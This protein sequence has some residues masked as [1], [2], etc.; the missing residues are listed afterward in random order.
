MRI[1]SGRYKGQILLTPKG[2]ITRPTS[3]LVREALFNILEHTILKCNESTFRGI[4]VLDAFAGS[5]ALGFESLSRGANHVT[6][7][8][9]NS[10]ALNIIHYNAKKLD[11]KHQVSIKRRDATR[12]PTTLCSCQIVLID[13]PYKSGLIES[14]LKTL[15]FRGWIT[16]STIIVVE[17]SISE[18]FIATGFIIIEERKYGTTRLIFLRS[19]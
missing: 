16:Y 11:V 9:T 1:I 7:L 10:N 6:F 2:F 5:G 3:N 4:Y 18:N 19:N 15:Q 8:E 14:T 17:L 13:P 12:P